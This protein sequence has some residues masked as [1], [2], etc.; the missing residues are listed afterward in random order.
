MNFYRI[1]LLLTRS[2]LRRLSNG[3]GCDTVFDVKS[4]AHHAHSACVFAL[5]LVLE[6]FVGGDGSGG[7]ISGGYVPFD[8]D[9]RSLRPLAA[10]RGERDRFCNLPGARESVLAGSNVEDRLSKVRGRKMRKKSA[11]A[12][13]DGCGSSGAADC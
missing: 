5:G 7:W 4:A 6:D 11:D 8:G 2:N 13:R 9:L 10:T 1:I 12:G 3:S